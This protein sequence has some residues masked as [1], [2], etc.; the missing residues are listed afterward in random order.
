M[1][2]RLGGG[3]AIGGWQ[4]DAWQQLQGLG[5]EL[6]GQT[7]EAAILR[8]ALADSPAL[9]GCDAVEVA[10]HPYH[11]R[12]GLVGRV[13]RAV[14]GGRVRVRRVPRPDA[15][16][17][18]GLV[19]ELSGF[20]QAMG[21][22]AL[23]GCPRRGSG[24]RHRLAV[25]FAHLLASTVGAARSL[26]KERRR[27]EQ[28][29]HRATQDGLTLLGN[30]WLLSQSGNHTL[31]VLQSQGRTAALLLFDLD[32]FK[33]VNDTLGHDAGDQVLAEMGRRL[34]RGIRDSD[35][36]VRLG[37]DEFAVLTGELPGTE[38]AE[39]LATRLLGELGE[40][41]RVDDVELVVS[42]SV[43]IAVLGEDGESV[44]E[45][46]RAADRA[47][48]DAKVLGAG[49]WRRYQPT[50]RLRTLSPAELAESLRTALDEGQL[51]V[52]LQPQVDATTGQVRG[53][54]ALVRWEHP[55][56]GLLE[57]REFVAHAERSGLMGRLTSVVLDQALA[58]HRRL[59]QVLPGTTVSVNMTARNLLDRGLATGVAAAL[60]EH[61]VPATELV[62]EVSEPAPGVSPLLA[63][64]FAALERLGCRVSV[65][66]YGSGESSL[67]ALSRYP[68]IREIKVDA[69]LVSAALDQPGTSRLV[70]AMVTAAHSLD[71]TVVAEGVES[72]DLADHMRLLGCDVLQGFAIHRPAPAAEIESWLGLQSARTVS[73]T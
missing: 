58:Q 36:A 53:F 41:V 24:D 45:L 70:R 73:D 31:S 62:L 5:R 69:D 44:D 60:A 14:E 10:I 72:A 35:L 21:W 40:P 51:V 12:P 43:G 50:L 49:Q 57:P 11:D 66:E 28:T 38:D 25:G 59:R 13:A 29:Y 15:A 6:V 2:T 67:T 3:R 22:L 61:E 68:G 64:A 9:L 4:R 8:I 20:G 56:L 23:R 34:R 65:S 48:Y 33:R 71:V 55:E 39:H 16:P 26:E 1:R 19:V 27:V 63:E 18:D 42:S 37:G 30:R 32:D 46:L 47:M 17:D 54:E 7:E 52:H